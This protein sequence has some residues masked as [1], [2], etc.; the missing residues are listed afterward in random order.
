MLKYPE[1]PVT[2]LPETSCMVPD[3][4]VAVASVSAEPMYN[5]PV[6]ALVLPPEVNVTVPPATPDPNA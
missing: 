4:P 1:L 5:A 3:V 2:A 6:D